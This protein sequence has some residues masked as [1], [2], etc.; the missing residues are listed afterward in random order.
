MGWGGGMYC[1]GS[2]P[3]VT[4]CAFND[5]SSQAGGAMY[6]Y[7]GLFASITNCIFTGNYATINGGAVYICESNSPMLT[8]CIFSGNKASD[9]GGMYNTSSNPTVINCT[10][11]QN[12]AHF[13]GGG[14]YNSNFSSPS[15][16]NCILW[17]D[18]PEEIY[19]Y[20]LS[21]PVVTYSNVQGALL[22][23]T[24]NKNTDPLFVN[25]QASDLR[26]LPGSPCI[27]AG[28]NTALNLPS[29]GFEDHP[30]II[31]GDCDNT[32]VVDMGAYELN[33]VDMGDFD[34]NCS[35]DFFD[36]SLFARAWMAGPEDAQWDPLC[37]ISKPVDNYIDWW[38]MAILCDNWLAETP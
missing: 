8:N 15:V 6:F 30:R 12:T 33:N 11:T 28:T 29:M 18:K 37:N 19:N 17:D 32:D 22:P 9:G 23:G 5:N 7:G 31:D 2:D 38:D 24:G 35:V 36:F 26:L 4:D 13:H 27:D 20:T 14:I 21:S 25:A 34:Y 1:K 3:V 10:F 16:T